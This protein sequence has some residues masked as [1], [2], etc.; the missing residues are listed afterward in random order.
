[1]ESKN[2]YQKLNDARE[3]VLNNIGKKSGKNAFQNFDYFELSDIV[4]I[5]QEAEKENGLCSFVSI[6]KEEAKITLVDNDTMIEKIELSI[7]VAEIEEQ[8]LLDRN[9]LEYDKYKREMV[10]KTK[11]GMTPA[12]REQHYGAISTYSRRYLLMQL[13]QIVELDQIDSKDNSNK[14]VKKQTADKPNYSLAPKT[15]KHWKIMKT[16]ELQKWIDRMTDSDEFNNLLPWLDVAQRELNGRKVETEN[17][18]DFVDSL[19]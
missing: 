8:D 13:Y 19:F 7:P 4:P 9:V 1:M 12:Q 15:G 2:I 3:Y 5:V 16:E 17:K 14:F 11:S 18:N 6:N 10:E